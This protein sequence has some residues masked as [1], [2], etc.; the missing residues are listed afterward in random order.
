[1][2]NI[3]NCSLY[4]DFLKGDCILDVAGLANLY[5]V[6][7]ADVQSYTVDVLT[8]KELETI[9]L[10]D[11][12]R[13]FKFEFKFNSAKWMA[14]LLINGTTRN[15]RHTVE[16]QLG[17]FATPSELLVIE[18]LLTAKLVA[19]VETR[20]GDKFMLGTPK[21]YLKASA[22]TVDSGA[23]EEDASNIS[24]TITGIV[25]A[26]PLIV[27]ASIDLEALLIPVGTPAV[28]VLVAPTNGAANQVQNGLQ[29]DWN[30]SL[31]AVSYEYRYATSEAA[32]LLASPTA[33]A[34]TQA[35]ISGLT[36]GQSYYWQV[37]ALNGAL[38]SDYSDIFAFTVVNIPLAP[39]LNPI[40]PVEGSPVNPSG[41]TIGY[42]Y[43]DG[44]TSYKIFLKIGLG[45]FA[46]VGVTASNSFAIAGPFTPGETLQVKVAAVNSAGQSPDSTIRTV[47][48]G[49]LPSNSLITFPAADGTITAGINTISFNADDETSYLLEI[50]SSLAFGETVINTQNSSISFDFILGEEYY[51]RV[52][53]VNAYG[54]D[55]VP[56]VRHIT[57]TI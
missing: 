46:E 21:A 20:K 43:S 34:L 13:A 42:S 36:L 22:V 26:M 41:F 25:A 29:L 32:L 47:S 5:L 44:A 14:E 18:Q 24:A 35:T 37:R 1:M 33:T 27:D 6:N 16:F 54:S 17:I 57:D 28:P 15:V 51:I 31:N 12:K 48:A 40:L 49:V 11:G 56:Y 50:A 53:G 19:F 10:K 4:D 3:A 30:A 55:P 52:T 38:V 45:A 7:A 23:A 2:A 9:V 8:E 39:V